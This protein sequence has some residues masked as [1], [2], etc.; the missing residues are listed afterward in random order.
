MTSIRERIAHFLDQPM[1]DPALLDADL[2]HFEVEAAN[3]AEAN[4]LALSEMSG[5]VI[6][7]L[8]GR[9]PG[10]WIVVIDPLGGP[11]R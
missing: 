5:T 2:M 7:T 6:R 10:Q 4:A 11:V 3:P 1:P 8:V 9:E